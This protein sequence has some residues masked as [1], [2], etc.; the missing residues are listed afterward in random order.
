MSLLKR[1]LDSSMVPVHPLEDMT[2]EKMS[3]EPLGIL[4]RR[5]VQRKGQACTEVLV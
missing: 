1:C 3:R 2:K 4:D 5:L